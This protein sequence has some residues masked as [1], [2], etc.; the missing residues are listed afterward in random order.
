MR[1]SV[2][3]NA[4]HHYVQRL[5]LGTDPFAE[6]YRS[7]YF[8]GGSQRRQVLDQV[9]HFSRFSGQVVMLLGSTG[10]GT[11]TVLDQLLDQL[12]PV[13]DFCAV[14]AESITAPDRVLD[15]LC[16]QL[17]FDDVDSA[18]GFVTALRHNAELDPNHEPLLVAVD[19]A[20][21]LGIESL[22]LLRQLYEQSAGALH[23]L[24]VGE[25]QVEQMATLAGFDSGQLKLLE[26]E[27]LT[28]AETG[29]YVLGLLQSVGYAGELPLSAD[30]LAVLHEQSA[31]N[32]AE[33]NLLVPTLLN[34][35]SKG[36]SGGFKLAIPVSHI[37]AI[38]VLLAAIGASYWYQGG[39]APGVEPAVVP[40]SEENTEGSSESGRV[41]RELKLPPEAPRQQQLPELSTPE[42]RR[43]A[44]VGQGERAGVNVA[45]ERPMTETA[46]PKKVIPQKQAPTVVQPKAEQSRPAP[47]IKQPVAAESVARPAADTGKP[48][49]GDSA[50]PAVVES[51]AKA[52]APVKKK[53]PERAQAQPRKAPVS[54]PPREQRLLD[55]DSDAFV[56]QLMGSVEEQR[57]RDLVK[58]HIG[59]IP[60]TYFESL[61]K[62]RPWFVVVTGP[63]KDKDA[64]RRG[65]GALPG[66]LQREKPWVRSVSGVQEEIRKHRGL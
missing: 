56:L 38:V 24:L 26:L 53:I 33:I 65:I 19:Q 46:I 32:I 42:E 61:L 54:I 64:A 39:K 57:A 20:H 16:S 48:V 35:R 41:S 59:R 28:V 3:A 52:K 7:D 34:D 49:R 43:V 11:S 37:A 8:Y 17:R 23:L 21:F 12:E 9:L 63:Y 2:A 36:E 6:G 44:E 1:Q 40:S 25:Y 30:Q 60:L 58:E 31:G 14:D 45:P 18:A 22:E 13:M 51:S 5:D 4:A 62:G 15:T 66:K 47:A 55:M 50:A 10:S 27:P 29:E